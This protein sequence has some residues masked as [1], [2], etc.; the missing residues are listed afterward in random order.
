MSKNTYAGKG[1]KILLFGEKNILWKTLLTNVSKH[2]KQPKSGLV[3]DA[4]FE[5]PTLQGVTY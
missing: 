1:L 3:F 4:N 2:S 5:H